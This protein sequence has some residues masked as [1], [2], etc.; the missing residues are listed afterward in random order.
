M[1]KLC[2]SAVA[3]STA[4]ARASVLILT[5]VSLCSAAFAAG[6][7]TVLRQQP[8]YGQFG[9]IVV[10]LSNGNFVV[11]DPSYDRPDLP[12]YNNA[13]AVYL[14]DGRT[15]QL[16]SKMIGERKNADL[17]SQ[18]HA[19]AN[20]NFVVVGSVWD[21]SANAFTGGVKFCSGITGC[22]GEMTMANSV[23]GANDIVPLPNGN[24]LMANPYWD[25]GAVVDAGIVRLCS[26]ETGCVGPNT[27][28]NSLIGSQANEQ[29]GG[30]F[31]P[32]IRGIQVLKNSDYV[33]ANPRWNGFR[34]SVT[35][36]S[37]TTGITGTVSSANSLVGTTANDQVGYLSNSK[38][39]VTLVGDDGFVVSSPNWNG[40]RGAATFCSAQSPCVGEVSAGNSLV[41]TTVN[42][43]VGT[44]AFD[45]GE[46][47]YAVTSPFWDQ[48]PSNTDTG[49]V[50]YCFSQC[51]G[52]VTAGNSLIG[53]LPSARA[54][55][56][57]VTMLAN[58]NTLVMSYNPSGAATF[59]PS[60]T[61]PIGTITSANSVMWIPA[62]E[63]VPVRVTLLSNGNYV[64]A[65]PLWGNNR[66]AVRLCP[67]ETGCTG[68]IDGPNS[69]T[70]P[71]GMTSYLGG[72]VLALPNGN[73][74]VTAALW[75]N[76]RGAVTFCSGTGGCPNEINE[77]T[78][79]VGT[80]S[81]DRVG[82]GGLVA[83]TNGN[84][85]V[86]SPDWNGE[87]GAVTWG[88]A[89][90]GATGVVSTSN[91]LT[92]SVAK[93]AVGDQGVVP[94][95][96]GDYV[97]N[98]LAWANGSQARAGA[99]TLR[100]GDRQIGEVV[101]PFNSLVG[102]LSQDMLG[103]DSSFQGSG[104]GVRALPDGGYVVRST[105]WNNGPNGWDTGA[106]SYSF[107]RSGVTGAVTAGNSVIG[108][109]PSGFGSFTFL[110]DSINKQL[111]VREPGPAK[112]TVIK[113][114]RSLV[115]F[116]YDGD[117]RSDLSVRRPS[118][119]VWHLLRAAAGY[120]AM[121]FGEAGDRMVPADYDGDGK[122]DVAVFRPSNGRWY[123][124]MSESQTFAQFGWG[125]AGDLP[126]P[127]DRDN[128]GKTDLVIFRPSNNTWY[129]RFANGTFNTFQF[130]ETGDK[131]VVGDF[132]A[133]GIGDVALF[134]PSN[135]NWYI[136]KSSLGF[137]VQTWGQAGDIPLTGDFDGDGATD[138]ASFRPATGQWFLSKTAEGFSSQSWGQP[139][140]IPVPADY[141]ADGRADVAVFRPSDGMWYI[142][143][144]RDGI[145][146]QQFGVNGD[147]P[148]QSAFA[149]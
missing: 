7:R 114:P 92:G 78:S 118:D 39:A 17:A 28:E 45:L 27:I 11:T 137:F 52:A 93:D 56:G 63:L 51:V 111:I 75:N 79:L 76:N 64:L 36:G 29:L 116:D 37:G 21:A 16:I 135:N 119:N 38:H 103:F 112:V 2:R 123:V 13:G 47:R 127:T 25:N 147:V 87:R 122:T 85:V 69:L 107:G 101:S 59:V 12:E 120:T 55:S 149:Y 70:G 33:I 53:G 102:S 131:P 73:Y 146:V 97:V 117:G 104:G 6:Q 23:V 74:V 54:G 115:N 144:S 83:L 99:I 58:G 49:A 100:R 18:V 26:G 106:I 90:M 91:S 133:D 132:D 82:G 46:G 14:Y 129:T 22:D 130:G 88:S 62:T 60:G 139:G 4:A 32:L 44:G 125:E 9:S 19:L 148:T 145:L 71:A 10:L 128:D 65:S 66:G 20:G 141:D 57:G 143:Q 126:V 94:L 108:E 81:G 105:Y 61:A 113:R 67:G 136:I 35:L 31:D 42:D 96:N 48:S 121:Q 124:Y 30:R 68:D 5:L 142:V 98:S 40:S 86:E 80:T 77:Q 34:G 138:Q 1:N 43:R 109:H 140:D 15:L 134:R 89:L 95:V 3:H 84:Y 50:T 41:G 72:Q 8:L 24:Y 110:Y